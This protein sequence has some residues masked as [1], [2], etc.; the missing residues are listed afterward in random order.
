M[1]GRAPRF[2]ATPAAWRA[3]LAKNHA[4]AT[5]LLVGFH[6]RATG[7]P[8]LTWPESVDEALCY[9]W[10]DGRRRRLDAESYEI[11]FTPRKK[12]SHWSL[13]NVRRVRE[14]KKAG[15]MTP[16]GARAFA[17][18]DTAR[19]GR[20]SYE[21][22]KPATLSPA[23]VKALRAN[24]KA[25]GHFHARPP[26]YRRTAAFWVMSAKREETRVKRLNDLIAACAA[27]KPIK[28]LS[29]ES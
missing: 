10:I 24:A 5:E 26:W 4:A 27:G 20:A 29:Y 15:L 21:A 2:F 23:F 12:G 8:S 28:P 18:R 16:A 7:R 9:G 25:W 17:A 13:V 1:T 3:W 11:R 14:L 19:T 6:K 22:K